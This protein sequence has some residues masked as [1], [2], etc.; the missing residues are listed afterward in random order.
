MSITI[1]ENFYKE[2]VAQDWATGTGNFYVSTKPTK[3][4]GRLVISPSSS[5]LREIVTYTAVGTDGTGDYV[6]VSAR[7]VGGTTEQTHVI[8]ETI[9]NN[10]TAETIQ[11][12]SD[13]ID[14]VVAGGAQDAT[15]EVKGIAKLPRVEVGTGETYALTTLAGERVIVFVSGTLYPNYASTRT[16]TLA[17]NGVTKNTAYV[18]NPVS[19]QGY[20][21]FN[22]MYSEIPGAATNNITV[23][24]NNTGG[25][26]LTGVTILVIKI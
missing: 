3:T 19:G 10:V 22:L 6:T 15:T 2:T 4:S 7:G 13:A 20:Y 24:C 25:T 18:T 17:Y 11:E 8:G 23:T 14:Q 16:V 5:T 21:G 12:I 9:R 26:G 1:P